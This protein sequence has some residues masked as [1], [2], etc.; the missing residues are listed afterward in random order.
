[1]LVGPPKAGSQRG[2]VEHEPLTGVPPET[3]LTKAKPLKNGDAKLS[4]L[5]FAELLK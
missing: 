2:G 1:M 3:P 5:M 4:R